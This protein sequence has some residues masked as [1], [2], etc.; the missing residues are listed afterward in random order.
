M[1]T[2]GWGTSSHI[3]ATSKFLKYAAKHKGEWAGEQARAQQQP[4]PVV[5]EDSVRGGGPETSQR[6]PTPRGAPGT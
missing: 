5:H 3:S 4:Q 6:R 2:T 1:T